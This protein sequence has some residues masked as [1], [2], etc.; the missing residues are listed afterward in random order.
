MELSETVEGK[1]QGYKF[2]YKTNPPKISKISEMIA[3]AS[4]AVG[5]L[6]AICLAGDGIGYLLFSRESA[7]W[8][9]H[10]TASLLIVRPK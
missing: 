2:Q 3:E 9:Q 1:I 6:L 7:V 4:L 5:G 10:I 8:L